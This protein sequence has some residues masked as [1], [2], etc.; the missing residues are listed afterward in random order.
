MA[1]IILFLFIIFVIISGTLLILYF[2]FE[3][4][5]QETIKNNIVDLSIFAQENDN[6]I[7]TG[8]VIY[9]DDMIY[10]EGKTLT[11]GAIYDS[12]YIN[13]TIEICNKNL[14]NQSY[15]SQ[16]KKLN[17][18]GSKLEP[19]RII[20][21]LYK[22]KDLT[23]NHE[24][25]VYLLKLILFSEY[26]KNLYLCFKYSSHILNAN[27]E[28]YPVIN[29][30]KINSS[31]LYYDKC[32]DLNTDIINETKIFNINYKIWENIDTSDYIDVLIIDNNCINYKC[33]IFGETK[34]TINLK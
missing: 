4:P 27:L 23:I 21:N 31:Y 7:E 32:H 12:I 30:N 16:C 25:D 17:L 26:Q 29:L 20:L 1:K 2:Y 18:Y 28:G 3:M 15:Y 34:Q 5:K 24:K 13:S 33:E 6:N 19:Q 9:K 11:D 14:N 8:Y 22:R 10:S